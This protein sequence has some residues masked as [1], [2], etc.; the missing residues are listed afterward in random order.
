MSGLKSL[1]MV[2]GQAKI[3]CEDTRMIRAGLHKPA[4]HANLIAYL[5][6]YLI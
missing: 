3:A 6:S 1:L 5:K 2:A 4:D